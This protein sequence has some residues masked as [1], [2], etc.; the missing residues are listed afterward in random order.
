[1]SGFASLKKRAG[2]LGVGLIT[3]LM[4]LAAMRWSQGEPIVQPSADAGIAIGVVL[5]ALFFVFTDSEESKPSPAKGR[6]S[7]SR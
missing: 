5:V 4:I 1:M 6:R 2:T 7:R 3:F